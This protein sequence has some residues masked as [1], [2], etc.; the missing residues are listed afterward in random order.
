[1]A[2]IRFL[3]GPYFNVLGRSAAISPLSVSGEDALFVRASLYG[4]TP[5]DPFRFNAV[6]ANTVTVDLN[7]IP[8]GSMET[9]FVGNLPTAAWI[10]SGTPTTARD[11]GTFHGGAASMSI[12]GA[13]GEYAAYDVTVRAG[14]S[15]RYDMWG[16]GGAAGGT[17]IIR[18]Q[19]RQTGKWLKS[20]QT[21]QS[22]QQDLL[23]KA[24]PGFAN[25]VGNVVVE[26][27]LS[28][29]TGTV[30]LRVYC[31]AGTGGNNAYYDDMFLWPAID[32]T[33]IHGH[34][35][36]PVCAV[37]LH[38]ST[39]NF[40]A[41]DTTRL[42]LT[43]GIPSFY[44]IIGGPV[45]T[46][47][48]WRLAIT[49]TDNP[50]GAPWVGEWVLG[51]QQT[52]LRNQSYGWKTEFVDPQ[53]RE[54]S[55]AGEQRANLL[56]EGQ[57]RRLKLQFD[58]NSLAKFQEARDAIMRVTRNGAYPCVIVPDDS[59]TEVVVFGHLAQ[60]FGVSKDFLTQWTGAEL[61]I[62]ESPLFTVIP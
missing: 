22:A 33:S 21:W 55:E 51:Q 38:S 58:Y 17:A 5:S 28:S 59:D 56:T 62:D 7:L 31:L 54:M 8:N 1:M 61:A 2:G 13:S 3:G 6:G 12:T 35:I 16:A 20:D 43:P 34:N 46:D 25:A 48:Y 47:R 11:T 39:D 14:E 30:T 52:L 15:F 32:F 24:S 27:F 50:G 45:Y 9:A 49:S 57:R 40:A 41:N 10:K 29:L 37:T 44:G 60:D 4:G 26:S 42:T 19:N 53:Q 18:I 23:S 36:S